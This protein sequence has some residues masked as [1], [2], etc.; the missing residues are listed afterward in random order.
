MT[1]ITSKR[2]MLQ[3]EICDKKNGDIKLLNI[4]VIV[5]SVFRKILLNEFK[6]LM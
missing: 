5:C 6:A 2:N 3:N 1:E 4:L